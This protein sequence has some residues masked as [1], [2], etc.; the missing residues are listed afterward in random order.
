MAQFTPVGMAQFTPALTA[1]C[2]K[3]IHSVL[4][5]VHKMHFVSFKHT[6][7]NN[8]KLNEIDSIIKEKRKEVN[9]YQFHDSSLFVT[10][11]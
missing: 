8:T 11:F 2:L 4:T 6:T 5:S 10:T 7:K 9:T 3:H 1:Y